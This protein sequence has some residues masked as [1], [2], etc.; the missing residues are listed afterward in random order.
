MR[1]L[2]TATLL[3]CALVVVSCGGRKEND[4]GFNVFTP[5]EDVQIGRK[6]AAEV[7]DELPELGD[8]EVVAYVRTVGEGLAGSAPGQRFPYEFHVLDVREINAFALPGGI[9]FVNRGT[10]E[11]VHDEGELAGVLAHEI[12]HVALRH[13]TSQ[14]SKAYVA[15]R[16]IDIFRRIFGRRDDA[17][18]VAGALGGLGLNTLFLRFSREAETEADLAGARMLAERGYDPIEMSRF[19]DTLRA[20]ET[21]HVPEF[22]SDHPD[23]GDRALAV[24]D[25]RAA[26]RVSSTPIT[27][28]DG[29]WRMKRALR[30]MPAA[31]SMRERRVGPHE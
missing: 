9:V 6:S 2:R 22:F 3:A 1:R 15:K 12:S 11:A 24:A 30:L 16:G 31:A 20:A 26:L 18:D 5:E 19:F 7:L 21:D 4:S 27:V 23:T 13:G 10:L 28:T 8:E 17:D 25:A 14:M 29:F